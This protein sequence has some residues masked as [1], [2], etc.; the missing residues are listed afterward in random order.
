M[1]LFVV[2]GGILASEWLGLKDHGVK[3]LGTVPQGLPT[4]GLPAIK[5]A[6]LNELLPL[7]FACFLLGAVDGDSGHWPHVHSPGVWPFLDC[8]NETC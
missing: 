2:I 8:K 5:W 1:A 6:D 4:F 3:L 7:P